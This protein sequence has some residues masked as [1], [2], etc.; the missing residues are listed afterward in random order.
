M[1]NGKRTTA[2]LGHLNRFV[3]I[4]VMID[5]FQRK[6][7]PDL[8]GVPFRIKRQQPERIRRSTP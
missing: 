5:G 2:D 4:K 8:T 6:L 1:R 7:R 3:I